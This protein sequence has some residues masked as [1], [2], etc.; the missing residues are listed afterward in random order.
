M[1]KSETGINAV[2]GG[3]MTNDVNNRERLSALVDG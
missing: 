1:K 3:T 2:A